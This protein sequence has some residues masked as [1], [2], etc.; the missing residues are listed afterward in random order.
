MR[1]EEPEVDSA[2]TALDADDRIDD[3]LRRLFR[4]SGGPSAVSGTEV[5]LTL[6]EL[7]DL[8]ATRPLDQ[9]VVAEIYV[10]LTLLDGPD[11]EPS[12]L[13][14]T[15]T[16]LTAAGDPEP[17][18]YD[19]GPDDAAHLAARLFVSLLARGLT[20]VRRILASPETGVGEIYEDAFPDAAWIALAPDE[21]PDWLEV[22]GRD[23]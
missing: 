16:G 10:E 8:V 7:S 2:A 21:R 15:A 13:L 22:P 5:D 3:L 4:M 17:L 14:L 6:E 19:S 9:L 20:D 23:R 18:G 1:G 12:R 11:R